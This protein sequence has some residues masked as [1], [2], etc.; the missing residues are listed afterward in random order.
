MKTVMD[1]QT[2]SPPF[3]SQEMDDISTVLARVNREINRREYLDARALIHSHQEA[4][5]QICEIKY[6][7]ARV[8]KSQIHTIIDIISLVYSVSV[9]LFMEAFVLFYFVIIHM[10][11][12]KRV[13]PPLRF[14]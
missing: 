12:L 13:S 8:P 4:H 7:T 1:S 14:L 3:F 6:N 9:V 10:Q 2:Q 11:Y 5:P